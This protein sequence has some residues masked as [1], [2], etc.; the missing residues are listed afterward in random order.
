MLLSCN[1][2]PEAI[3]RIIEASKFK[4]AKWVKDSATGETW[5]WPAESGS[6]ADIANQLSI[7]E[8][9]KGI[10]VPEGADVPVPVCGHR[11]GTPPGNT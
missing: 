11:G 5:Y 7:T 4:A 1:P 2:T 10:A 6:H 8:Y 9:T 3:R